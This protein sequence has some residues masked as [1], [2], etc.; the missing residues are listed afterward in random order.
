MLRLMLTIE[1]IAGVMEAMS[2]KF[3]TDQGCP[4]SLQILFQGYLSY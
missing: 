4:F 2:L 1:V 3:I